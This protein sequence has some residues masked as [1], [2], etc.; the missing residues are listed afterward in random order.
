MNPGLISL[1]SQLYKKQKHKKFFYKC[2]KESSM[3]NEQGRKEKKE[4]KNRPSIPKHFNLLLIQTLN[5]DIT[6]ARAPFGILPSQQHMLHGAAAQQE[7]D[8]ICHD[9]AVAGT[10]GGLVL[11]AVDVATDNTVDVAPADDEAK[12][13]AALVNALGVVGGPGNG[14]GDTGVD[15]QRAEKGAGVL[16]PGGCAAEQHREPHDPDQRHPHITQPALPRAVGQVT[17]EDGHDACDGVRGNG[18]KLGFGRRFEA[19]LAAKKKGG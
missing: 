19:E 4:S 14:V 13:D 16:H 1:I 18:E 7:Q 8:E 15:P 10:K 5:P 12:G 17:D 3:V 2:C 6:G 11:V 9:D